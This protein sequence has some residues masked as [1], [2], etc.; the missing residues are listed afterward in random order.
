M[1]SLK[2]SPTAISGVTLLGAIAYGGYLQKQISQINGEIDVISEHLSRTI[3]E[4][5]NS[6]VE[7]HIDQLA[8]A[9]NGFNQITTKHSNVLND[10]IQAVNNQN[11]K[12]EQH[13]IVLNQI[14]DNFKN[15][16]I[17]MNMC[18]CW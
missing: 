17:D 6:E 10:L 9:I 1:D 12:I 11:N 14:V 4:V 7:E 8:D 13:A 15:Q 5:D 3:R 2:N 18:G 16:G